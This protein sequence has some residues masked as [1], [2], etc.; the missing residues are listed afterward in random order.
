MKALL[1]VVTM[2]ILGVVLYG[3]WPFIETP[4][5]NVFVERVGFALGTLVLSVLIGLFWFSA[6]WRGW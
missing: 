1:A 2:I 5:L 4:W 6:G 3:I